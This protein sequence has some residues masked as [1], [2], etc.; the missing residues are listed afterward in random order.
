MKYFITILLIILIA[1][2]SFLTFKVLNTSKIC[3]RYSKAKTI[4]KI[5]RYVTKHDYIE[6]NINN[7]Y[8]T[9]L[10][11]KFNYNLITEEHLFHQPYYAD[12]RD[13][14]IRTVKIF[15]KNDS[16]LQAIK[17]KIEFGLFAYDSSYF[18]VRS[19]ITGYNQNKSPDDEYFGDL[20]IADLNFDDKEDLAVVNDRG[21]YN[22][23]AV[24]IYLQNSNNQFVLDTFLTNKNWF[25]NEINKTK[26]TLTYLTIFGC[27]GREDEIIK[28]ETKTKTWK[29]LK[30]T[31]YDVR[32]K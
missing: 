24:D 16:F 11:E 12:N 4:H 7:F 15:D 18:Y 2:A 5:S 29:V 26:K 30:D 14:F 3:L 17:V 25:P 28:Y 23:P 20:I 22:G 13:S 21:N 27:C 1:I 6:K 8:Y 9:N 19:Y 32:N 10:S 31:T